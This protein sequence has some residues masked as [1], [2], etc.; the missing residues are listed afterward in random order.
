MGIREIHGKM[1]PVTGSIAGDPVTKKMVGYDPV[2]SKLLDADP[3][4]GRVSSQPQ[5]PAQSSPTA[6]RGLINQP[7][8]E[9]Q[10]DPVQAKLQMYEQRI[11][12]LEAKLGVSSTPSTQTGENYRGVAALTYARGGRQSSPS[13]GGGSGAG[14]N[15][16]GDLSVRDL[17][18]LT[19]LPDD[20]KTKWLRRDANG[21][22][23]MT[24]PNQ[25]SFN[26]HQEMTDY[27]NSRT[28]W[29]NMTSPFNG[30]EW[31]NEDGG[32]L[33]AASYCGGDFGGSTMV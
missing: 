13:A 2:S 10:Q 20:F 7:A 24:P 3:L 17:K 30:G 5:A 16:L 1:N 25:M 11:A 31:G 28:A 19:N 12:E 23:E 14:I 29:L 18:Q 27:Y 8:A 21:N 22:L 26:S 4:R 33:A 9:Q 15:S 32:D 6:A